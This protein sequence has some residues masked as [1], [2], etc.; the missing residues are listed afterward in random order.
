MTKAEL[1]SRLAVIAESPRPRGPGT[2]HAR[3][4]GCD[5]WIEVAR[6]W[7][8]VGP[9]GSCTIN[10]RTLPDR[11][12]WFLPATHGWRPPPE[13]VR[14]RPKGHDDPGMTYQA[15]LAATKTNLNVKFVGWA[16]SPVTRDKAKADANRKSLP[17]LRRL[18]HDL[19]AVPPVLRNTNTAI[20]LATARRALV[21]AEQVREIAR[22]FRRP[23]RAPAKHIH[24]VSGGLP[25]LGKSRL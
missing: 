18:V 15:A 16:R 24:V 13:N 25:G 1:R 2:W 7:D 4:P 11:Y 5:R 9:H 20:R 3:C 12:A 19:M 14:W 17:S 21:N 8:R 23:A 10:A 22:G 6:L